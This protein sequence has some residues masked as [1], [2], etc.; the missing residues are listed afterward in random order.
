MMGA[1]L[2]EAVGY[3]GEG[4]MAYHSKSEEKQTAHDLHAGN[5]D[6]WEC[7]VGPWEEG[8]DEFVVFAEPRQVRAWSRLLRHRHRVYL[9]NLPVLCVRGEAQTAIE[10]WSAHN[11][12]GVTATREQTHILIT[13]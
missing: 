10:A 11:V 12:H 7:E 2:S 5:R 3:H 4:Q 13:A 6:D 9:Q 1:R 8:P